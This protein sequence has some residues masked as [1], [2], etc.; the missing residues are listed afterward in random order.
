MEIDFVR[1]VLLG[2][3]FFVVVNLLVVDA[4]III[5]TKKSAEQAKI[6]PS[7]I[8]EVDKSCPDSCL[9]EIDKAKTSI[10]SATPSATSQPSRQSSGQT[11]SQQTT[12]NSVKE[13]FIPLGSGTSSAD[14]WTDIPGVKAEIDKT[15]YEKIQKILFEVSVHVPKA[16]HII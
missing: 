9:A 7:P 8:P 12:E 13:F 5:N 14:D 4:W 10:A 1:K 6:T 11:T 3:F 15:K 2:L 16:N